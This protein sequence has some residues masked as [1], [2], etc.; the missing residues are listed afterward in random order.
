MPTA[1]CKRMIWNPFDL[2]WFLQAL[3]DSR[4]L[5]LILTSRPQCPKPIATNFTSVQ[6]LQVDVLPLRIE[7]LQDIMQQIV[8]PSSATMASL[9]DI[10]DMAVLSC[11]SPLLATSLATAVASGRLTAQVRA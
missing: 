4:G 6:V 11:G 1:A 10:A 8:Y 7:A 2:F 9:S 3:Q 5:K